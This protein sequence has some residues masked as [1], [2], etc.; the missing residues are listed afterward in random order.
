MSDKDEVIKNIYYDR[1]GYQSI[2]KTY[3]EAKK[4]DNTITIENVRSWFNK[5]VEVKSKPR[6][7]NSYI[8]DEPYFEYQID[9]AFWKSDK[10]D[11]SLVMID[12]FTKFATCIPLASKETADVIAGVM[13]GFVKMDHKPKMIYCDGEGALRSN[14]FKEF[15]AE[16]KI[17]LIQTQTHAWVVE[18][19]IRT[20]KNAINKRLENDETGEKTWKDFLFEILLTY[21]R[22]DI[23]SAHGMTPVQARLDKNLMNVKANLEMK[24]VSKRKYPTIVVGSNVKVCKK[25]TI[26]DKED[27]SYWLPDT[28]KVINITESFG[29]KYYQLEGYK[30]PLLRHEL[31]KVN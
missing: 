21:N 23:H 2:Q 9:L 1:S 3:E 20:M 31:L 24:R 14:L 4:K 5:N 30:R 17:K 27:K 16:R 11:P 12:I 6:G 8:A 18:R 15:C 28:Y 10:G 25:K 29:Q 19:F 26:T 13:E 7:Y 22:K